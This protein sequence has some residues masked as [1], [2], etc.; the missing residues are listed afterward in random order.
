MTQALEMKKEAQAN[1]QRHSK[2]LRLQYS[3]KTGPT[4]TRR[5]KREAILYHKSQKAYWKSK[6]EVSDYGNGEKV[7][8]KRFLTSCYK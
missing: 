3:T 2:A 8:I 7:Q 1:Y 5:D 4:F 6:M